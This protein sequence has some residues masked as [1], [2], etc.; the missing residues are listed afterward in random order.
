MLIDKT[1]QAEIK[2]KKAKVRTC[3]KCG[4]TK[5][6]KHINDEEIC[7]VCEDNS[8]VDCFGCGK[9]KEESKMIYYVIDDIYICKQSCADAKWGI[10][11][12]QLAT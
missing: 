2:A 3:S 6:I 1:K 8:E 12:P 11:R 4:L 5:D 7:N 9:H 10:D